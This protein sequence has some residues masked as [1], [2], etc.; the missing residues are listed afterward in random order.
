M[1]T[2]TTKPECGPSRPEPHVQAKVL[3]H[4][5]RDE[6]I[7][8]QRNDPELARFYTYVSQP[9]DKS[10]RYSLQGGLLVRQWSKH[11]LPD[12]QKFNANLQIVV[13]SSLR[14]KI[15]SRIHDFDGGHFKTKRCTEKILSQF[16]W[17]RLTKT[18]RDYVTSCPACQKV[19]T[20]GDKSREK[21]VH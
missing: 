14:A 5:T 1:P 12:D 18:V 6:L 21:L 4:V 11:G 13:P 3:S 2:P 9:N 16:W 10:V 15:L 19:G 8:E 17:P 7:H 20:Q